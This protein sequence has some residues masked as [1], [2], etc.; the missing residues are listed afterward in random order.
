MDTTESSTSQW[1]HNED[2]YL[3]RNFKDITLIYQSAKGYTVLYRATRMGKYFLLKAL[4]PEVNGDMPPR[5]CLT[6]T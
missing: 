2:A 1:F 5:N 4:R 6:R 3:S